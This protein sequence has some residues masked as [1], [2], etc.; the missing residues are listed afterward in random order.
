MVKSGNIKAEMSSWNMGWKGEQIQTI[1]SNFL[2]NYIFSNSEARNVKQ[3]KQK[4]DF[5]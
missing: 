3:K 1:F 5:R 2:E 4:G